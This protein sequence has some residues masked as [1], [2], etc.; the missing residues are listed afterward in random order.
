[1]AQEPN[2]SDTAPIKKSALLLKLVICRT[3]GRKSAEEAEQIELR[4]GALTLRV[5]SRENRV[6]SRGSPEVDP[7]WQ[8]V[9]YVPALHQGATAGMSTAPNQ[10]FVFRLSLLDC[11]TCRDS[12]SRG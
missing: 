12:S 11:G 3:A 4:E 10:D 6:E 1:M 8:D 9:R 5:T 7:V 2:T